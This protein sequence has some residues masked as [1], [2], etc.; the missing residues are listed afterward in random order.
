MSLFTTTKSKNVEIDALVMEFIKTR[1][2]TNIAAKAASIT[3][4]IASRHKGKPNY[5]RKSRRYA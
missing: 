1:M 3:L 2:V 4:S 5:G